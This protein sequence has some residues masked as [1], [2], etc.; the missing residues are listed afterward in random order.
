MNN[1]ISRELRWNDKMCD[2][3]EVSYLGDTDPPQL[4]KSQCCKRI[5][6]S[7]QLLI[8]LGNAY[9]PRHQVPTDWRDFDLP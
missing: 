8:E 9:L 7:S 4:P 2:L 3:P 5:C 6:Q 1:P